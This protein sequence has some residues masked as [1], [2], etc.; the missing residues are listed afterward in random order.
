VNNELAELQRMIDDL[1]S[2]FDRLKPGDK[3]F[4]FS[5]RGYIER[6]GANAKIGPLRL[7]MLRNVHQEYCSES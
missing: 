7:T 5:W 2:Y 6:T 4:V 3:R 1:E